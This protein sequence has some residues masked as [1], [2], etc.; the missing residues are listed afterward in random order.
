MNAAPSLLHSRTRSQ[1]HWILVQ[2]EGVKSNRSAIGARVTCV[3]GSLRQ[4]DEV[5][6]GGSFFSQND[7]RLHFGLGDARRVDLLEIRWP[8]G[9]VERIRDLAVDRIVTVKE[10]SGI[11]TSSSGP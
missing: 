11:S 1:N 2:L 6:S 8:D 7:L 10:G 4:T 5:R 3:T 9:S